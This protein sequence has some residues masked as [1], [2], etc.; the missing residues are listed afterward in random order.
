MR[1]YEF[2]RDGG[3]LLEA[4]RHARTLE[5]QRTGLHVS[6]ICDDMVQTLYPRYA[7][8]EFT[9]VQRLL[10]QELG[11]TVED[12]VAEVLKRKYRDWQKPEPRADRD[13]VI[14]SPD[15]WRPRS[16]TIDEV[17]LTWVSEGTPEKKPFVLTDARGRILE[18][19]AKFWRYR[20]QGTKY[21]DMWGAD[22]VVYHVVFVTGNN[23]PPFPNAREFVLALKRRDKRDN[24]AMLRQHAVDRG[25]LAA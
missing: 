24:S 8:G 22:R 1:L 2:N 16:R 19:S 6:T 18:E 12:V 5:A 9:D 13:G 11:C 17:K 7:R 23:R 3:L 4:I 25:M 10:F 14:G 20:I 15:G 21:A